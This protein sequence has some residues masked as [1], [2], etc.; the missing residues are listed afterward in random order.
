MARRL[1]LRNLGSRI[2]VTAVGDLPRHDRRHL[3]LRGD[4]RRR[5]RGDSAVKA[6]ILDRRR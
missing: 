2:T 6:E 1:G 5:R 4:D 3:P